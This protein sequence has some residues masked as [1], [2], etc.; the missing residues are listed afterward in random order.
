MVLSPRKMVISP[1]TMGNWG[2]EATKWW[3]QWW[4]DQTWWLNGIFEGILGDWMMV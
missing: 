2:I 1:T 3:F 4:F